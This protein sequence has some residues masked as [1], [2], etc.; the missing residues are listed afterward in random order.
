MR[1]KKYTGIS[2]SVYIYILLAYIIESTDITIQLLQTRE[3]WRTRKFLR[4]SFVYLQRR[5]KYCQTI[6]FV[7]NK[8]P[9]F[10]YSDV[11]IYILRCN[12]GYAG[13]AESSIAS[14][15]ERRVWALTHQADISVSFYQIALM[16]AVSP[17]R[18]ITYDKNCWDILLSR[19]WFCHNSRCLT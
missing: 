17:R 7:Q 16:K 5:V 9:I 14:L 6:R 18:Q 3:V 13:W 10:F 15:N 8:A 2:L 1:F 12:D 19:S 4:V 11:R